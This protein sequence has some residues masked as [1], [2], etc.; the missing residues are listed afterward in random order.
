MIGLWSFAG[1]AGSSLPLGQACSGL[2][3]IAKGW[4]LGFLAFAS[5]CLLSF[6]L[7]AADDLPA[8]LS[9]HAIPGDFNQPTAVAARPDGGV[10]VLDGARNRIVAIQPNGARY[11]FG[12]AGKGAGELN[13]PLDLAWVESALIVADTGNHRLSVFRPDGGFL[14]QIDL[15]AL[16]ESKPDA[17]PEPVAVAFRDG[18]IAWSDR[19][20]HRFC[21]LRLDDGKSLGCTGERGELEGQFQYPYQIAVDRDGYWQV[22]DI[23]NARAQVFDRGGR[24]FSQ[25]GRFGLNDSELFRPNGL[26]IDPEHDWQFIADSY[27]GWISVFRNGEYLGKLAAGEGGPIRFNSPTG[28]FFSQSKLYVAETGGNAIQVL[29]LGAGKPPTAKSASP[30][31]ITFSQKNCVLC[32]LS[33]AKDAPHALKQ[34]DRVGALADSSFAM[35]YS[36]HNGAIMDSRLIIRH[37]AQHPS[38]YDSDAAK[39]RRQ[40]AGQRKDKF[41]D[42]FP[43]TAAGEMSCGTCHTP[44]TDKAGQDKLYAGHNNAWLRVPNQGGD[45]CERCH[46]S[47]AQGAREVNPAKRGAN[48]PLAIKLEQPPAPGAPGYASMDKLHAGRLPDAISGLGGVLGRK[49]EL[50]CQSCHQVHGGEGERQMLTVPQE[51]GQLCSVCHER[52]NAASKEEAHKKGV[53]PVNFKPEEAVELGGEK[54]EFLSCPT[55]H[56]VH[57]GSPGTALL[58]KAVDAAEHLCKS[59][60]QRHDADGKDA[61]RKKGVHPVNEKLQEAV[62]IAGQKIEK[63]GCLSCHSVHKG[64]P[65]T[66]ALVDTDQDGRLCAYCHQDKQTVVGSDHDLRITAKD[67]TNRFNQTPAQSG[68]CGACHTLHQ[69]RGLQARLSAARWVSGV[70]EEHMDAAVFERDRLCLNCHQKGGLGA[71]KIAR[72]FSHPSRDMVLR[73]DKTKMP[74]LGQD[75]KE[76]EFGQIG[77]VTCHEPHVWKASQRGSAAHG[78]IA[79]SGNQENVEGRNL[80]SFLRH[81]GGAKG[82]FCIDCH[83][84]EGLLK[85]KYFHDDKRSRAKGVEYLQ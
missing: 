70:D 81:P 58:P 34:P 7:P 39:L 57:K 79:V 8:V 1:N 75:E 17:P 47:K 43:Q 23:L 83:G 51:K 74:L 36:C 29:E 24:F 40:K 65:N 20:A 73:S 66:A 44:H 22:L 12:K 59:C 64:K 49:R 18:I 14:R 28:L 3:P 52:Q 15:R 26:A 55:C 71:K 2:R 54:V 46:E 37:G 67:K 25:V 78:P 68:V 19:R 69:G 30:A 85:Y 35:C 56:K 80:E 33:W 41:P 82:T 5:L 21:R 50:V 11:M 31:A 63:L 6:G 9:Q 62:E 60:H 42:E 72:Y 84:L 10:F 76:A 32:H 13:H 38:L 53:H 48:H 77:C 16:P 4:L 27:F 45:L 61:A